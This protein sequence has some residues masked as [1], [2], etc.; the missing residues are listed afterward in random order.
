MGQVG[1]RIW[2]MQQYFGMVRSFCWTDSDG[3]VIMDTSMAV[4]YEDVAVNLRRNVLVTIGREMSAVLVGEVL[5]FF[6]G[7]GKSFRF[8]F[9]V[10]LSGIVIL[11]AIWN[12]MGTSL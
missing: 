5:V 3:I 12:S 11:F 7:G 10:A 1:G 6:W 2:W 9:G 8:F 4:L